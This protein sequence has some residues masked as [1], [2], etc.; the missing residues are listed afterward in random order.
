MEENLS[1]ENQILSDE[2]IRFELVKIAAS[3]A[4]P[5]RDIGDVL[6]H[7]TW[8]YQFVKC[9]DM[10]AYSQRSTLNG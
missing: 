6:T 10:K 3:R 9:G 8:L 7:A 5:A 1:F 4:L 2:R